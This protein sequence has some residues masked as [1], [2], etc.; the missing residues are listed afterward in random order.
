LATAFVVLSCGLAGAQGNTNGRLTFDVASVKQVP[1]GDK[2]D[3]YQYKFEPGGRLIVRHFRVKDLILVAWHLRDFEIEGGPAWIDEQRLYYDIDAEAARNPTNDKMR[4]MLQSLL[5]DRFHL[6]AHIERQNRPHFALR[7]SGSLGGI[8]LTPTE[9]GSCKPLA[10][11]GAQ[12]P[13]PVAPAG[14]TPFCGFK[15]RLV[16]W[17]GGGTAMHLEWDGLPIA[18]VARTLGTEL[19]R[20]V[21]DE[22]GLSGSYDVALEFRP[23]NFSGKSAPAPGAAESTAPS[24]FAAVEQQLGLKLVAMKGPVEVLVIDHAEQPTAN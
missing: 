11:Y 2:S 7:R 13:L 8:G 20:Q 16:K 23:D 22:T 4:L 15:A 14:T 9:P 5:A 17:E 12:V 19:Y 10:D 1:P 24:I 18:M 21:N 6:V 3:V